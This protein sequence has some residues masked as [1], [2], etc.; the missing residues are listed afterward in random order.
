MLQWSAWPENRNRETMVGPVLRIGQDLFYRSALI[1]GQRLT[2]NSTAF[3][4][5]VTSPDTNVATWIGRERGDV[6][7]R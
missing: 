3:V 6:Y 7:G 2:P 4:K 1:V 5:S